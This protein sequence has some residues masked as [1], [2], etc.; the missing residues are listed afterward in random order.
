MKKWLTRMAVA[1]VVVL[2]TGISSLGV[3]SELYPVDESHLIEVCADGIVYVPPGTKFVRCNGKIRKVDRIEEGVFRGEES[4]R[5]PNCCQGMCWVVVACS[6]LPQGGLDGVTRDCA[7][8]KIEID[9]PEVL[10][11]LCTMWLGC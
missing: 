4:C 2:L 9:D 1:A 11:F 3:Q 6:P 10:S 7:T 8:G 5:C